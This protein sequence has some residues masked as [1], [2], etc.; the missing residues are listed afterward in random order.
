MLASRFLRFSHGAKHGW[1]YRVLETGF[2]FLAR[3]YDYTLTKVLRHRF[4][5]ILFAAIMLAGTVYLFFTMPTGF[6]P[7]QDSGF[8]FGITMAGQEISFE[9][10]AQ[11]HR[12]LTRIM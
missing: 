11:H 6:I 8:V 9:S 12:P 3:S 10:M 1:I 4:A 2:D 5:T 7:S